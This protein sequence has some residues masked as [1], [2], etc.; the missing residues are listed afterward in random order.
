MGDFH[1]KDWD[2]IE[3]FLKD[4]DQMEIFLKDWVQMEM[5][6]K[7]LVLILKFPKYLIQIRI[8]P[9]P[10]SPITTFLQGYNCQVL[11]LLQKSH[12]DLVLVQ[13]F[14]QFQPHKL[15]V[16]V[17]LVLEVNRN[18]LCRVLMVEDARRHLRRNVTMNMR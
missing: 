1:S 2:Q 4:L 9:P 15:E 11:D 14:L 8:F 13:P 18:H 10:S 17:L 7:D 12:L 3:I 6:H 16:L 5:F